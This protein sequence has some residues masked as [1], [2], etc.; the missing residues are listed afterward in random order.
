MNGCRR[1]LCETSGEQ[2]GIDAD[3]RDAKN[4][5]CG[6]PCGVVERE[7]VSF[8]QFLPPDA[9]IRHSLLGEDRK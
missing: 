8:S 2:L 1:G 5:G 4:V 6:S 9:A 3:Q 7:V